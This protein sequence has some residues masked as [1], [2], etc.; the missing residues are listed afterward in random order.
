MT[1]RLDLLAGAA[2]IA[3][4]LLAGAALWREPADAVGAIAVA[5]RPDAT[6][7]SGLTDARPTTALEERPL[8][9]PSRRAKRVETAKS[10]SDVAPAFQQRMLLRGLVKSDRTVVALIEDQSTRRTFRVAQGS[11]LE[12]ATF[13]DAPDEAAIFRTS[14]GDIALPLTR[15]PAPKEPS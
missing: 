6:R 11:M 13:V 9:E 10:A 7:F 2:A 1:P 4:S 8:F 15:S 3:A 14:A 5:A 12:G